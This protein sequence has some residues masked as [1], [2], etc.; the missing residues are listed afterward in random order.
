MATYHQ[1]W[2]N[3][4]IPVAEKH[5]FS[6]SPLSSN[7]YRL[8]KAGAAP[9]LL[10]TGTLGVLVLWVRGVRGVRR[11]AWALPTRPDQIMAWNTKNCST[12][13]LPTTV[14]FKEDERSWG[15]PG[16]DWL[17]SHASCW[18]RKVAFIWVAPLSRLKTW[19]I[20]VALNSQLV[21]PAPFDVP[22]GND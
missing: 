17:K 11:L 18:V 19:L 8:F 16:L 12:G 5:H 9:P 2:S 22:S 13:Q 1:I 20:L 4:M 10:G 3:Q 21:D 15:F 6:V 7:F 14:S